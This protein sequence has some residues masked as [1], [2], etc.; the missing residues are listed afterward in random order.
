MLLRPS[1][2]PGG[3]F[4]GWNLMAF[5][6]WYAQG[7][8]SWPWRVSTTGRACLQRQIWG[9]HWHSES[10]VFFGQKGK[11]R[12]FIVEFERLSGWFL[13]ALVL[14]L[15]KVKGQLYNGD[16]SF[17]NVFRV[18]GFLEKEA[19]WSSISF[20]RF[21]DPKQEV[22]LWRRWNTRNL[23]PSGFS[24][25]LFSFF[26]QVPR[27]QTAVGTQMNL[28]KDWLPTVARP[29]VLIFL[30]NQSAWSSQ[31]QRPRI[32]SSPYCGFGSTWCYWFGA[33]RGVPG[34]RSKGVR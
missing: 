7:V 6:W 22:G 14:A 29:R 34:R 10:V 31:P 21:E 13:I 16:V 8:C 5:G 1:F 30:K 12:G 19:C 20:D 18:L 33:S 27:K 23:R 3:F 4:P 26:L 17:L 32:G 2:L 24:M 28:A 11:F 25:V 9:V 15:L